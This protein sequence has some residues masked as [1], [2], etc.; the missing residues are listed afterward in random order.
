VIADRNILEV[1]PR[2]PASSP[3]GRTL[4]RDVF[5]A[6]GRLIRAR[7]NTVSL[8]GRGGHLLRDIGLSHEKLGVGRGLHDWSPAGRLPIAPREGRHLT[9]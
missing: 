4:A 6:L 1:G 5:I 9:M 7:R 8:E 2:R 3:G